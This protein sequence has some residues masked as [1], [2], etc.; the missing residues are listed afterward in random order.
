MLIDGL[1]TACNRLYAVVLGLIFFLFAQDTIAQ[2]TYLLNTD[3]ENVQ[4][5]TAQ[6]TISQSTGIIAP[7]KTTARDGAQE[8][9]RSGFNGVPSYSGNQFIELN[10]N[11]A[12]TTYQDFVAPG[13]TT[14]TLN[15]AHRGRNGVDVMNVSI[16]SPSP[17]SLTSGTAV[18]GTTYLNLGN[19]SDGNTA[20]G[21]YSV[22]FTLPTGVANN[23]FS[24]RFT[25]VSAAG[26]IT[27]I[28]N[29]LDAIS[30]A[31]LAPTIAGSRSVTLACPAT[32]TNLSGFTATNQPSGT[33]Q[34]WHTGAVA[35][36]AN[37][38][39]SVTAVGPGTYYTAFY[40]TTKACYGG[41][42]T[43]TVNGPTGVPA[44]PTVALTQPVCTLPTGTIT[45]TA[46]LGTGLTYSIDGTNYSSSTV[47]AGVASGT[48]AVRAR[49]GTGSLCTSVATSVTINAALLSPSAPAATV[50]VQ[51]NCTLATGTISVTAPT[52][53]GLTYSI[54]GTTYTNTTGL[55]TAV[56]PGS[57]SVTVKNASGCIS[58]TTSVTVNAQPVTPS[59]SVNSATICAGLSATLTVAGCTDGTLTWGTRD[60]TAT[61]LVTPL[62]TTS[63]SVTCMGTSGCSATTSTTV[64]VRAT[65]SYTQQPTVTLATCTGT[66]PNNNARITFTTL[67]NTE[68]ADLV[69]ATNYTNGP[70]YGAA[71]NRLVANNTVSFTNLPNPPSSQPYTV[72]LFSSSG[73]CV[74]DVA[75][76]LTPTDCRC[77]GC[78]K[79]S[80]T[81]RNR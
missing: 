45:I 63:Y 75:I 3:F 31:D 8:V 20:W 74:V 71:S 73:L 58:P 38:L 55:F 25:S 43:V 68:R 29:F 9:W 79:V 76:T 39:S 52:G 33:T 54:N 24:I 81:P 78:A 32:T 34:T 27:S 53:T 47:F 5:S 21:Y 35:T 40:N 72:R 15:F 70:A 19:F 46:P 12:A 64:T 66:L 56:A 30:I 16:G 7:W 28:G 50:T 2:C 13:G 61:I 51:P 69:A 6:Q 48:Y 10:A 60:N 36:D 80:L 49:N 4:I 42:T 23:S 62:V 65:P 59:L 1:S 41:T 57:Y 14:F 17:T 77:T 18:S 26:G 37:R 11:I 44:A 67:Q 22:S